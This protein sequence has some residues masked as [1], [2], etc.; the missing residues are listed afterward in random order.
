MIEKVRHTPKAENKAVELFE[1]YQLQIEGLKKGW[2]IYPKTLNPLTL[3]IRRK[4][5]KIFRISN[6]SKSEPKR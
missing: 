4:E 1:L 5:E 6:M 2:L 3:T